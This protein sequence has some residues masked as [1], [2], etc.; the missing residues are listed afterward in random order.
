MRLTK[1]KLTVRT[2]LLL[3]LALAMFACG[4]GGSTED[5]V[6]LEPEE[7]AIKI[8]LAQGGGSPFGV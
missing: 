5:G 8:S 3:P 7:G 1:E 4:G 2:L 6:L